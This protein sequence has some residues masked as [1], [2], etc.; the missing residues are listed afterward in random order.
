MHASPRLQ[1]VKA[2]ALVAAVMLL[3]V[4]L[5]A[6]AGS[7]VGASHPSACVGLCLAPSQGIVAC[8]PTATPKRP[9]TPCGVRA[10]GAQPASLCAAAPACWR[11][12]DLPPPAR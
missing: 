3:S 11:Q 10:A 12:L 8:A 6:A 5:S 1:P 9:G 7:A 4:A 2:A